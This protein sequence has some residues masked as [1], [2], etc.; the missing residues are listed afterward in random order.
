MKIVLKKIHLEETIS[1]NKR[2][3]LESSTKEVREGKLRPLVYTSMD[4]DD[5]KYVDFIRVFTYQQGYVPVNPIAT[6]GYYTSTLGHKGSKREIIKDCYSLMLSCDELWVFGK[7]RPAL[8]KI[9]KLEQ[10]LIPVDDLPEGVL[11]ELL[12]WLDRKQNAP[13]RF[14]TWKD[15]GIP[16][17]V[18]SKAWA[19]TSHE[20]VQNTT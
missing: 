17:Y 19:L 11:A 9:V 1:E 4:G 14:F 7:K 3:D 20:A 12:V 8:G 18:N 6:L 10:E 15:V 13:V 5:M 2:K 16:K